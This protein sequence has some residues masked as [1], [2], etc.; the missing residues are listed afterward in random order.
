V[1]PIRERMEGMM[2]KVDLPLLEH[3]GE[4]ACNLITF[5]PSLLFFGQK[6]STEDLAQLTSVVHS[7]S[8]AGKPVRPPGGF[9]LEVKRVVSQE[10]WRQLTALLKKWNDTSDSEGK[11]RLSVKEHEFLTMGLLWQTLLITECKWRHD[12]IEEEIAVIGKVT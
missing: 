11:N 2:K 5:H 3:I 8:A 10:A 9:I 1:A 4:Y 12:A 6:L 7:E